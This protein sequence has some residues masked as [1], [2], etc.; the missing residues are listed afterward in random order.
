MKQTNCYVSKFSIKRKISFFIKLL[1]SNSNAHHISN[2]LQ[3]N[4]DR[5]DGD[6]LIQILR[7]R[8]FFLKLDNYTHAS[9]SEIEVLCKSCNTDCHSNYQASDESGIVISRHFI[10]MHEFSILKGIFTQRTHGVVFLLCLLKK[11]LAYKT[12]CFPRS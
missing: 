3:K 7:K 10:L 11:N 5:S 12:Y 9:L 6:F 1:K 4:L 2:W 8:I